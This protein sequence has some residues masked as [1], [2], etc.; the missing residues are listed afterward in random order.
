MMPLASPVPGDTTG[1]VFEAG[2]FL[3]LGRINESGS[4][5]SGEGTADVDVLRSSEVRAGF[6]ATGDGPDLALVSFEEEAC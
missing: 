2:I 4:L 3:A 1:P 5:Y 6:S